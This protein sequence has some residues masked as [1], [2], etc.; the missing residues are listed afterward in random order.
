M[1][2][3]NNTSFEV[4]LSSDEDGDLD[5][6]ETEELSPDKNNET[7]D[8]N[9]SSDDV[10]SVSSMEMSPSKEAALQEAN[11][12]S[13]STRVLELQANTSYEVSLSADEDDNL[14]E[15]ETKEL[16]PNKNDEASDDNEA[17][18]NVFSQ[19]S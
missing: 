5:E 14:D 4:S 19:V 1:Q 18:E 11:V 10:I 13:P 16:S 17:S 9:E 8:D 6:S 15:S 3:Q 2:L 12:P 7:S